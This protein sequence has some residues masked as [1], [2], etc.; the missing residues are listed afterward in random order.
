MVRFGGGHARVLGMPWW[1]AV[2][3]MFVI[4]RLVSTGLL[5][6]YAAHQEANAWTGAHPSLWDFSSL[7]DG[8]WYNIIEQMGYPSTLPTSEGGQVTENA[9]AFLPLY[10]MTVKLLMTLTGLDWNIAAIGVSVI[11]ALAATLVFYRLMIRL[12]NPG[13]AFFA[14]VLFSLAP[15]SPLFQ[16]AYAESMQ[17][18]LIAVAL[19]LLVRRHYLSMIPVLLLLGVTRPGALAFALTL[20][21]H[22]VYRLWGFRRRNFGWGERWRV[23][24]AA[25][26]AVVAGFEWML[27]AGWVTGVPDAYLK[28]ELA[29]RASY[30]GWKELVP[31]TPWIEATQWWWH[32]L[33]GWLILAGIVL[34]FV[35]LL[36][37]PLAKRLGTDLR[38]WNLSY[39]VY[40]FAV[41]FPQSSTMRLLAP[42]FPALGMFAVPRARW[43]RWMLVIA[44]LLLQ[45]FWVHV[46]WA[47]SANDWSPP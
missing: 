47:V 39:T 28:T 25:A 35:A 26:A 30:L 17:L 7:W 14:V 45:W 41:F 12:L 27:I 4:G 2:T 21:L 23:L 37:N 29:W 3:L 10:P 40:L 38:L 46:M 9:W 32:G 42:L 18:L 8:R 20:G 34:G 1:V 43:Y 22:F 44:C 24:G 15:V 31:F 33:T 13:Q 16:L 11:C 5:L 36:A 6:W 19:H